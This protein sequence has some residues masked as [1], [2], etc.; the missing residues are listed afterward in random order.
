MWILKNSKDFVE[1]IQSRSLISYNNIK[2]FDL[3]TVYTTIS[4]SKLK[5][6]YK[7]FVQLCFI[8]KIGQRRYKYL[9]IE[10]NTSDFV[11]TLS[12]SDI[13]KMLTFLIDNIFIIF[14]GRVFKQTVGIAMGTNC[15]PLLADLFFY[16]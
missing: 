4:H 2:T 13:I 14:G 9:V 1:H 3:S 6:R 11:K 7:E 15:A 8:K 16:S 12:E 5:G 10:R